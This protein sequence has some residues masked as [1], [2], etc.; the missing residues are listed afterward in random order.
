[1]ILAIAL[2]V[3]AF[4]A[5]CATSHT[6][7]DW[8]VRVTPRNSAAV[9]RRTNSYSDRTVARNVPTPRP[10]PG[11][12]KDTRP[13]PRDTVVD[14]SP[15]PVGNGQFAWPMNGRVISEF[16]STA[17]GE[18]NDGIN[19]AAVTGNPIRAAAD[20]NVSYTGNDLKN[21]GNLVLIRHGDNYVTAYAHAER[22]LVGR[23][24]H[25]VKG[26]II[27]YAG[28]TGDVSSPQLH[29]EIRRGVTPVNP[30]PLLGRLIVAS[31]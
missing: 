8:G 30:R 13:A 11:W 2:I 26:Q 19:I 14:N 20:G 25:V 15:L 23:G 22:I 16:G 28:D 7:L 9:A 27:A 1:M 24:D 6:H 18:R 17:S 10:Q 4:L 5:G 31:R 3:P 21:Y 29:F 12:Y